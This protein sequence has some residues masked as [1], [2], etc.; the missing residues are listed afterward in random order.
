VRILWTF[1][2]AFAAYGDKAS[3]RTACRAF[4]Y[5]LHRFWDA[6][7]GGVFRLLDYLGHPV[8]TKKRIY[9]QAFTVYALAEYHF[10]PGDK[11]SLARAIRIYEAIGSA[12]Y[13]PQHKEYFET[14]E[15][16]WTLAQEQRLSEVD[17]DE[18]KS[19]NTHLH[20]LAVY[21]NLLRTGDDA[22]CAVASRSYFAFS[23]TTS[24]TR[25]RITSEC[26]LIRSGILNRTTSL[27]AT[28]SK[29]VG[30]SAKPPKY[31]ATSRSSRRG[32]GGGAGGAG[33]S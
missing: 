3:H 8:E 30:F 31:M 17:M 29:E 32:P 27:S 1:S 21:A 2:K 5:I 15:R 19:M 26:S 6:E 7:S 24:S 14:Y 25:R 33:S 10:G 16:D 28:T 13:D 4:D 20:L 23:G 12:R 22:G 11:E 18:K 9:R